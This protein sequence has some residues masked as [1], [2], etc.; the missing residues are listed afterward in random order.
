MLNELQLQ[1]I[2]SIINTSEIKEYIDNNQLGFLLF[3]ITEEKKKS[4]VRIGYF[5]A[6]SILGGAK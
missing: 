2:A 6:L 3:K 5:G 1:E 4:K